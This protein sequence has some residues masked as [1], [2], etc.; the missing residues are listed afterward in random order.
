MRQRTK[1]PK[2]SSGSSHSNDDS[3]DSDSTEAQPGGVGKAAPGGEA[4]KNRS[5]QKSSPERLGDLG[6][7][8]PSTAY[9]KSF[10]G[11]I[12]RFG[13]T[14]VLHGCP[15]L[16]GGEWDGVESAWEADDNPDAF[17]PIS[18]LVRYLKGEGVEFLAWRQE[19]FEGAVRLTS[20]IDQP[21][22]S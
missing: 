8:E 3:S 22:I 14:F 9:E 20:G 13:K 1:H 12:V 4:E 2:T 16:R 6:N 19:G 7:G 15:W 11:R 10:D 17:D 5:S 21:S 18:L